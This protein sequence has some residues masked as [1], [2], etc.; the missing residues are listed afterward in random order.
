[1]F[2]LVTVLCINHDLY[3]PFYEFI[4]IFQIIN[5]KTHRDNLHF[6]CLLTNH[7][8]TIQQ[9]KNHLCS[10]VIILSVKFVQNRYNSLFAFLA[11]FLRY[12]SFQTSCPSLVLIEYKDQSTDWYC[13][14]SPSGAVKKVWS[15]TKAIMYFLDQESCH[16]D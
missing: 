9:Y 2:F 8:F 12:P 13:F 15:Q 6:S 5:F 10:A 3:F 11:E 16:L 14:S 4:Y 7:I 1:M